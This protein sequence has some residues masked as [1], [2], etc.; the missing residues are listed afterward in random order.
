[1]RAGDA[2]LAEI[3]RAGARQVQAFDRH[4]DRRAARD[5]LRLRRR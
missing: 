4:L 5:A 1:M 3:D 2:R